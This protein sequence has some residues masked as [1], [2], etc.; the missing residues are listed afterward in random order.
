MDVLGAVVLV[1][2]AAIVQGSRTPGS[3]ASIFGS[4]NPGKFAAKAVQWAS[5]VSGGPLWL[6]Q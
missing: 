4:S 3:S 1:F 2:G 6:H 5:S